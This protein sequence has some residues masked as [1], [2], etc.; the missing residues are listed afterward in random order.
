MFL[1]TVLFEL[2]PIN[3]SFNELFSAETA[4]TWGCIRA[5]IGIA[6]K[7][8]RSPGIDSRQNYL[9]ALGMVLW[10]QLSCL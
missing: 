6:L 3:L 2:G 9:A 7:Y 5:F 10:D 8:D 1:C 4:D